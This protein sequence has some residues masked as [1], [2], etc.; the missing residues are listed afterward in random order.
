MP[1]SPLHHSAHSFVDSEG[2]IDNLITRTEKEGDNLP[3]ATGSSF[4]FAKLWVVEKDTME[5]IPEDVSGEA[6]DDGFWND[7]IARAAAEKAKA[8]AAE[9][10]G[11]GAKRR[12]AVAQ[13]PLKS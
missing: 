10:T 5:E 7:V 8:K 12:A 4:G 1:N 2:D 13:V 3:E 11:R 6:Q 9:V